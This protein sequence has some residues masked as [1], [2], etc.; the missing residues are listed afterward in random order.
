MTSKGAEPLGPF[1]YTN[2]RVAARFWSKVSVSPADACW[3]WLASRVR[4]YGQFEVRNGGK[5]RLNDA[6]HRMAWR[7]ACGE[8]PAGM[9]VCHRCDNPPCVNPAHLFLGT[10]ADNAADM[11]AKGRSTRGRLM[12]QTGTPGERNARAKL[13]TADVLAMR[14]MRGDGLLH[15]EIAA[16]FHVAENTVSRILSGKRWGHIEAGLR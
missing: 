4:G 15:R 5:R 8:I 10:P 16:R 6:A 1:D 2:A 11:R 12:P 3:V 9:F 14:S 13:S 7:I